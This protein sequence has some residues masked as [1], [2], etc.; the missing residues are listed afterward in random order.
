M[1]CFDKSERYS[2]GQTWRPRKDEFRAVI[3]HWKSVPGIYLCVLPEYGMG[4]DNRLAFDISG[5]VLYVTYAQWIASTAGTLRRDDPRARQ[6]VEMM[7][8]KGWPIFVQSSHYTKIK[9]KV[10]G[11][12]DSAII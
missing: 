3:R 4:G 9:P 8:K 6:F 5:K 10:F 12:P 2:S 11:S 7:A 1:V